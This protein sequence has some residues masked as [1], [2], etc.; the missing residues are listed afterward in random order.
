MIDAVPKKGGGIS[1]SSPFL[2]SGVLRGNFEAYGHLRPCQCLEYRQ[3][4]HVGYSTVLRISPR[5][6]S[7]AGSSTGLIVVLGL[8]V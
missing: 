4:F 6:P 3:S 5:F 7:L 1:S 2:V 8:L